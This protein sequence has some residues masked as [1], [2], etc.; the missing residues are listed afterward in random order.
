M[1][2][3]HTAAAANT[4][5]TVTLAQLHHDAAALAVEQKELWAEI[6]R[7]SNDLSVPPADIVP[8][9]DAYVVNN[10]TLEAIQQVI[11]WY[12]AKAAG[13]E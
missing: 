12:E 8:L 4:A 10:R 11:V 1:Q 2:Q 6:L 7:Q 9:L 5:V 3:Q 13:R